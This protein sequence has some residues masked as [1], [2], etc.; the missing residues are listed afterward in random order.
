M[1][2]RLSLFYRSFNVWNRFWIPLIAKLNLKEREIE[3]WSVFEKNTII[4]KKQRN[5]TL[6]FFLF[7]NLIN[8]AQSPADL[9]KLC[10]SVYMFNCIDIFYH[11]WILISLL[12]FSFQLGDTWVNQ[13]RILFCPQFIFLLFL[14]KLKTGWLS[15]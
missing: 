2:I 9:S 3:K 1:W 7:L 12:Q 6:Y 4:I 5:E 10:C 15:S 14:P 13:N 11:H 8:L